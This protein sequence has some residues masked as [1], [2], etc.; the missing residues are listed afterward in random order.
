MRLHGVEPRLID[1]RRHFH[2]DDLANRLQRLVPGALVELVAADIGRSRQ[3]AVN[4]ADAPSA[5]R[6]A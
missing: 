6:L 2:G 1:Q 3:D 4:L 5:R